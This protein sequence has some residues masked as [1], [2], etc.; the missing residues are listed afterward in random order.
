MF[1]RLA[2]LTLAALILAPAAGAAS[3]TRSESALLSEMNRVRATYKLQPLRLNRRLETAS[4]FHSREMLA[5]GVFEHGAFSTRM[6]RFSVQGS[7]AGENLAWGVGYNGS[8]QGIVQAWLKS[9]KHRANLLR[10]SFRRVGIAEL[11]GSFLGFDGANVV[12]AD[13]AG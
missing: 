3:L 12:T 4:R 7:F 5:K 1:M 8:A 6:D 13:F 11:T 9:P 2:I 10:P